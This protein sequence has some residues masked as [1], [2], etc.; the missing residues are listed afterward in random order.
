[1]KE[2]RILRI[3][4]DYEIETNLIPKFR[5]AI[6]NKFGKDKILFHNHIGNNF[7]YSYP[8]IQ[9]K[10][11][12][13][14]ASIISI[15]NGVDETHAIFNKKDFNINIENNNIKLKIKKLSLNQFVIQTNNN[16]KYKYEITNWAGLN[17]GNYK[18]YNEIDEMVKQIE[19]L[20]KMLINNII[21]FA[22][23]INWQIEER[24]FVKISSIKKKNIKKIKDVK[25]QTFTLKFMTN[26]FLPNYIGL[27]K[28]SSIGFG[29]I[30]QC[31]NGQTNS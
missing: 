15:E 8:L 11:L 20:E 24:I 9:Y 28:F 29:I 13:N 14:Y 7:R 18:K 19:F 26:V 12:Y 2:I 16:K 25:I 10:S 5:G 22:K 1:M 21:A 27:G 23:G 30:K 17:Q 6:I 31:K 4:F 3:I